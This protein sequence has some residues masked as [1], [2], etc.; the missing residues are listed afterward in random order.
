M[1]QNFQSLQFTE[2]LFRILCK[3]GR[4]VDDVHGMENMIRTKVND[5]VNEVNHDKK[6]PG[7]MAY[8]WYRLGTRLETDMKD[9]TRKD[10][11]QTVIVDKINPHL[12]RLIPQKGPQRNQS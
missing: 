6:N 5:N 11:L 8:R 12:V 7:W 9:T 3:G 2:S 10:E 1:C 4:N